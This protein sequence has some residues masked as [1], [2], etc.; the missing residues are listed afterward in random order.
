MRKIGITTV[1]GQVR[2]AL[3]NQRELVELRLQPAESQP[4]A[5]A[6]YYGKV[7]KVVP[8]IQS[9]FLD[10]GS[11]TQAYL[12]VEEAVTMKS[13]ETLPPINSLVRQGESLLV[14]VIKEAT[15]TKAPRLTTRVSLQG[16]L[17]VYFPPEGN[18]TGEEPISLSR[19]LKND[20]QRK[21]LY[22]VMQR[23]LKPGESCIVRTE[24]AEADEALLER[25]W[26]FLRERWQNAWQAVQG[27]KSPFPV[28][29]GEDPI[30]GALR[31]FLQGGAHA[32]V[33]EGAELYQHIRKLMAVLFPEELDK[34]QWYHQKERLWEAWVVNSQLSTALRREVPLPSGGNLVIER[35]E[36]LTVIDVNTGAFL[37]KGG[38]QREQAVTQANLEAAKEIARQL[39]LR[40]IG[41]MIVIDFVNMQDTGNRERVLEAL[42]T[43]L[44][45]DPAP[46]AVLGM[47]AL[48]L[49]E[50]TRKRT[51]ASL[52]ELLTEECDCCQGSGRRRKA[53]EYLLDL[54][55]DLAALARNQ[56]AEAAVVELSP[57]LY[58]HWQRWQ[59]RGTALPLQLH[60][61]LSMDW[62]EDKYRIVYVG[63]REEAER[64][65]LL[66]SKD[67]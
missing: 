33:V 13:R 64:L 45:D 6:I 47:T 44:A 29:Q 17:L 5:G 46:T 39:R 59:A 28:W 34:L 36:A 10:I 56:E 37:G 20:E 4:E 12:Y 3:M 31:D 52:A 40:G 8:G 35:T 66:R 9:A 55:D 11:G 23:L 16:R 24:A 26:L 57:R 2:I 15:E 50:M 41:G 65:S 67:S 19:K 1:D 32:I 62:A 43:A 48:G 21:R 38:Q 14:Q 58:R 49:V 61:Y 51:K 25:E 54:R 27:K 53:D 30:E 63:N 42:R 7:A 60:V 22:T 18:G